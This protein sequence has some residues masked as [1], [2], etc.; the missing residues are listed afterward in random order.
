MRILSFLLVLTSLLCADRV[1]SYPQGDVDTTLGESELPPPT[2]GWWLGCGFGM[3]TNGGKIQ[4]RLSASA[5]CEYRASREVSLL[6]SYLAWKNRWSGGGYAI[7]DGALRVAIRRERW[8]IGIQG[9]GGSG[10]YVPFSL[11]YGTFAEYSLSRKIAIGISQ[12]RFMTDDLDHFF[13]CN[14]QFHLPN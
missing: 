5:F 2:S 8:A 3:Q 14:I 11:H 9:G 4:E 12:K 7:I 10:Y 13:S 6:L 1:Q